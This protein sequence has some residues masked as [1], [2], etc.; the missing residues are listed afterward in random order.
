[1]AENDML[2]DLAFENKL[3][4]M[5][6][7]L[8]TLIKFLARE[9]RSTGKVLVSYGKRI[10]KIEQR[11]YRF[12]GYIG[13]AGAILGTAITATLDYLIRRG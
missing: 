6:D 2:D 3:T 7:D 9:Q 11:N 5:E 1:M 8:P 4:D 13:A 10:K 12:F